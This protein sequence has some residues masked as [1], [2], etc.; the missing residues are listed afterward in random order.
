MCV[1]GVSCAAAA[2][3]PLVLVSVGARVLVVLGPAS[4][5]TKAAQ[6]K[7]RLVVGV[8]FLPSLPSRWQA[9]SQGTLARLPRPEPVT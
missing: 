3:P 5:R 1:P 8:V 7:G 9:A 4:A 6:D 2:V